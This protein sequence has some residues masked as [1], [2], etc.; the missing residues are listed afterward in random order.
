MDI[1]PENLQAPNASNLSQIFGPQIPAPLLES[2]PVVPSISNSSV[3]S[4]PIDEVC[5][6][7]K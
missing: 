4:L 5:E 2:I 1:D 6:F 7:A 3:A